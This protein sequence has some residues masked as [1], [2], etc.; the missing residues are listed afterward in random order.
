MR[1]IGLMLFIFFLES[2]IFGQMADSCLLVGSYALQRV[3]MSQALD[4]NSHS[5]PMLRWSLYEQSDLADTL[6]IGENFEFTRSLN[7]L[8]HFNQI[9]TGQFSVKQDS[10]FTIFVS[11]GTLYTLPLLNIEILTQSELVI[12]EKFKTRWMRRTFRK[13]VAIKP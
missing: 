13:D 8:H 5:I 10:Q 9:L 2:S 11:S 12:I 3:E 7:F 4:S 1:L 6:R